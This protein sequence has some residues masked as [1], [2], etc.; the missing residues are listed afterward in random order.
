VR[1]GERGHD[2][3][4]IGTGLSGT[5]LGSILARH[6]FRVLL[7]DGTQHPRF[8]VGESTIGQTLFLLRLIAERY[9]V[10][11]IG[12]LG[13]FADI[14]ANVGG[15][16]GQKSNFGFVLH[17]E[18]QEPD[19]R[20]TNQL[21]L[22]DIA[23][24][25]AHLFRQD[26]DA[27]MFHTAI[28]YG[29]EAKQN[30][31]VE[32]ID[33][34]DDGV[35]VVGADGSAQHAR[36]LVDASGFRS[37]LARQ[38]GLREQPSRLHHHARS[39]FTHMI[40]VDPADNHLGFGGGDRPPAPWSEGTL[41]HMF[42]RGWMWIIP[43]DNH[44]HATN[45]LCSVGIQLDPRRY[46]LR[47][48]LSAE[49]EF[50]THVRRFPAVERQLARARSVREWVRTDRMQYSSTRTVGTR[51][52][53]MSH[54][55]GFIDPLF[56]R[57]LSNTCEIINTLS[58]RLMDALRDNDFSLD[59]FAHVERLEQG[60]LDYN[61]KLVNS[62]F[63]AFA[64]YDLWNA[65]F[66]IWSA[67]SMIGGKRYLNALARTKETGDDTYCRRL[68]DTEHP[69]LWW[70]V[71]SYAELFEEVNA[72]CEDVHAERV[73][74]RDAAE[75]LTAKIRAAD[76]ML[77]PLGLDRPEVRFIEPTVDRMRQVADWARTHPREEM[78]DYLAPTTAIPA[79]G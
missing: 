39:I 13:S 9:G 21:R 36:Y 23:G 70:P 43:F 68:D 20:E 14:M 12:Y 52:C 38:L 32:R 46:P 3:V 19:P 18:G 61:D 29:C 69:G 49:E 76:W 64:T 24:N 63:I 28:R 4:I 11:E 50:F 65:V 44:E 51:W 10:P 77:P 53:L 54:A 17:H 42:E 45:P 27:Y 58:W 60:L 73:S 78:R 15:S 6:G 56:S 74:A 16:H 7:L 5:I 31:R 26:S 33:F 48:E 40:G 37:P 41:H 34:A 35:T 79:G 57:G 22:L 72:R 1:N 47:S 59:R 30:Y 71:D 55:A 62:S 2:V 75:A 8:A 66:R 25:A 67:G